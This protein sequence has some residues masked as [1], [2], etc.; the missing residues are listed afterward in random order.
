MDTRKVAN[1][2]DSCRG[3]Q[4]AKEGR[5]QTG[6]A[7]LI[8]LA[9]MGLMS[10]TLAALLTF[11][12]TTSKKIGESRSSRVQRYEADGAIKAAVN[13]AKDQ[14]TAALDPDL[15]IP[16]PCR[17]T[18]G[19]VTV[20]CAAEAGS[21]SGRPADVGLTP[22]EA[23]LMLGSRHN[24]PGPNNIAKCS[25]ILDLVGNWF[26][27]GWASFTG[28][29]N[30]GNVGRFEPSARFGSQLNDGFWSCGARTRSYQEFLVEG[31][32]VAAGKIEVVS[33]GKLTAV[34]ADKSVLAGGTVA[35][36]GCTV[37]VAPACSTPGT[38]A[39]GSPEDSDPARPVPPAQNPTDIKPEWQAL[40]IAG[41]QEQTKAW[42]LDADGGTTTQATA[43][44]GADRTIVFKPGWYKNASFLN[45]FTANPAC[46]DT[47][48]WFAPDAGPDG[49][50]LTDDDVSGAFLLDFRQGT[51]QSCHGSEAVISQWCIG[52]ANTQNPRVVV[53]SPDGW[54][55]IN[56]SG[57]GPSS[58]GRILTE[59]KTAGTVDNDLSVRWWDWQKAQSINGEY[60]RYQPCNVFGLFNCPSFDRAIRM[61]NFT[62]KV[63][64]PPISEPGHPAG[65][66]FVDIAY[67]M[68]NTNGLNPELVIEAVSSQSGRK[69][70][71]TY[72][73][74]K[75]SY[76]GSGAIPTTSL[77]ASQ[78]EALAAA[79]GRVDLINGLEIKFQAKGNTW[80]SG[81]PQI[82]LDGVKIRYETFSGASFPYVD[83]TAVDGAAAKSD[84]DPRKPG[85]QLIF[86]GDS[87]VY[88]ADGSL[89]VCAGPYPTSPANHQSIGVFAVPAVAPVVPSRAWY[90]S[91]DNTTIKT[92]DGHTLPSRSGNEDNAYAIEAANDLRIGEAAGRRQVSIK[93]GSNG[94]SNYTNGDIRVKMAGYSPPAGFEVKRVD[95]RVSYNPNSQCALWCVASE[96]ARFTIRRVSSGGSVDWP[97]FD[98]PKNPGTLQ[99]A[100]NTSKLTI[101][102]AGAADNKI[103]LATLASGQEFVHSAR[104]NCILWI[105]G[106][107]WTDYLEGIEMDVTLQPT[108]ANANTPMLIPQSGCTVAHPNYESGDSLPDCAVMKA[109]TRDSTE[110]F[111]VPFQSNREGY[112]AGRYS[113]K[114][115]IYAPSSAIEIDDGD[116]A[117]PL[118]TRGVVVRH[119][120]VSGWKSRPNYSGI[121]ISN[122]LD[123]TP[124]PRDATFIAC[125]QSAARKTAAAKCESNQ[126]DKI[127]A[128]SRVRFE[129]N[130]AAKTAS[131][132]KVQWW[133]T[134]NRPS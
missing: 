100:N 80:N 82:F 134:D 20:S 14:P 13:W 111:T 103:S 115:T 105:C 3:W 10:L 95:L 18:D 12:A 126:G 55:P 78:A 92:N 132:P 88:V 133:S 85:G 69:S 128:A 94:N 16:S 42:F 50:L 9:I 127:L 38:R 39:D 73:I 25:G 124:A 104:A 26:T 48:F 109:D 81:T 74:A 102:T 98:L 63:T 75:L 87:H 129:V 72:P 120:R 24:E 33:G 44:A 27:S 125:E 2:A 65:R 15:G 52:G 101:Y 116:Y 17:Y 83:P 59:V 89:E 30:L 51:A 118:A 122:N 41:L 110:A 31:K 99:Y 117:Y 54:N 62:T 5:S 49:K 4:V 8:A 34:K 43:C 123:T 106:T 67:G 45:G 36:Y 61:R 90:E 23:L 93:Y 32:V 57:S 22:P 76:N 46:A 29:N 121:P 91:G 130:S 47:T 70:C 37:N 68:S 11:S 86:T 131:V 113:V 6:A 19:E 64:G 35:R 96:P 7:L 28:Q 71:G 119:L 53:G 40:P 1:S 58:T 56:P 107:N 79:C 21:G 112:W 108:A 84:C 66:L 77:S 97:G 114:G 60:A